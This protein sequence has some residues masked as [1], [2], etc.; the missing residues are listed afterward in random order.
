MKKLRIGVD[1]DNVI[2]QFV[3]AYLER[4]NEEHRTKFTIK[5]IKSYYLCDWLNIP[6]DEIVKNIFDMQAN[7]EY[8][9]LKP[10]K[11]VSKYISLLKEK[12][13]N[14]ILITNR[15]NASDTI[16]WLN[17]NKI[18]FDKVF[19]IKSK[20]WIL[21]LLHLDYY[22]EDNPNN[23]YMA[24]RQGIKTIIFN[25]PWNRMVKETDTMK[26]AKNWKQVVKI[27]END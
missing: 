18:P 26:R 9:F 10:T 3:P 7:G 15:V 5:D 11:E 16:I 1:V 6:E 25:Q 24:N 20:G 17:I 21:D 19:T 8:M 2:A 4:H 27:I 23:A 13:H 14:V 12:G 22:I